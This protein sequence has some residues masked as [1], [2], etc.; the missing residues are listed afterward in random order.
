MGDFIMYLIVD[1]VVVVIKR[2]QAPPHKHTP[3][4]EPAVDLSVIRQNRNRSH[5]LLVPHICKRHTYTYYVAVIFQNRFKRL[6][7]KNYSQKLYSF[8]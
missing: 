1:V 2:G 8:C 3:A 6:V 5:E 4:R 7:K